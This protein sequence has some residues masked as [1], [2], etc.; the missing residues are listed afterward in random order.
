MKVL[1]ALLLLFVPLYCFGGGEILYKKYCSEC[2]GNDRS[3]K[4]APPLLPLFLKKISL[5]KFSQILKNGIPSTQ[6]PSFDFL[7]DED[8]NVLY[9]Y[10]QTPV[11]VS[12]NKKDIIKSLQNINK[13]IK[14][15]RYSNIENVTVVVERGKNSV[16]ILESDTI[17]GKFSFKNIHGGIK[18]SRDG[19]NIYIPARDGWIGKVDIKNGIFEKKVRPCIYLRNID[20]SL[21]NRFLI[22]SCWLPESIVVLSGETLKPV[23]VFSLDGKISAV[24]TL[25]KKPVAV[26]SFRDKEGI[27]ILDLKTFKLKK[28]NTEDPIAGFF[29]DPF[30][31]YL[32]GS[33]TKSGKLVVYSLENGSLVFEN[34]VP[35]MPHLFSVAVWYSDGGFFFA[36]RHIKNSV[37]SIWRM[38]NWKLEKQ[39]NLSGSGFFVRTHSST[40]YLWTDVSD[41]K[42]TLINKRNLQI[43]QIVPVENKKFLHTEFS[44]DGKI[45]YLSIYDKEGFLVLLNSKTLKQISKFPASLPVGKY[46][47]I[48]KNR[49]FLPQILGEQ[50]YTQKCWGCHHTVEEAFAPSFKKIAMTRDEG[51]IMAQIL[52]PGG[53]YRL[54]GYKENYM[55]RFNFSDEELQAVISFI[56][57]FKEEN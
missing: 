27:H 42:V 17:L 47:Y 11:K 21:D 43:K 53:T 45:A 49:R 26:F 35:S 1:V 36:T 6:M 31:K 30:D 19:S 57:K 9:K 23:K 37:L 18:F 2:H 3:G 39:I 29:I 10:L 25:Y 56:K 7:S 50:I 20:I 12:W 52:N 54:L 14:L 24:Y 8:I 33:S 41:D 28:F 4:L 46:N 16:W 13:K 48:N 22:A 15:K 32:I 40:P 34:P 55:P 5:E 44:G 38:Y 51:L